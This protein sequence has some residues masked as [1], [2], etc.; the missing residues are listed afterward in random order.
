MGR[1]GYAVIIVKR[2]LRV[3]VDRIQETIAGDEPHTAK[4]DNDLDNNQLND[5]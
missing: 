3:N 1:P 2:G 4:A 5:H